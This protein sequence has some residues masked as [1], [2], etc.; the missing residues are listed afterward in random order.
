[1]ASGQ[2]E[3]MDGKRRAGRKGSAVF[4]ALRAAGAL[5]LLL[6]AARPAGAQGYT[7]TDLGTLGG[8]FSDARAINAAGQVVGSSTL[9]GD[10]ITHAFLWQ[11]GVMRDLGTLGGSSS[12]TG[13]INSAGQIVGAAKIAG[14]ADEHAFLYDAGVMHDLGTLGGTSSVARGINDA[15]QIVGFSYSPSVAGQYS[16]LYDQGGMHSLPG[17][18]VSNNNIAFAIN[19]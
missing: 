15:G 14:D 12:Y 11:N 17:A 1:M 4:Q 6:A 10:T 2:I 9:P 16:F 8:T 7:V 18:W 13:G 5:A 19:D 3:G